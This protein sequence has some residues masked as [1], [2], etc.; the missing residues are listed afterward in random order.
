MDHVVVLQVRADARQFMNDSNPKVLEQRSR[1]D[2][3]DLQQ[4][5]RVRRPRGKDYLAASIDLSGGTPGACRIANADGPLAFK[6]N[7]NR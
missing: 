2:T 6:N 4:L 7:F 1:T 5:R 3:R